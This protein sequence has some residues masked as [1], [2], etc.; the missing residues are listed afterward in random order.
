[1]RPCAG[2]GRST[3]LHLKEF[4]RKPPPAEVRA[5]LR[6]AT[7]ELLAEGAAAH[8]VVNEAVALTRK[9]ERKA[10]GFAGLVNA[11]R[12]QWRRCRRRACR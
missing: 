8:G 5:I 10:E 4:V 2:S 6:L 12:G 1:M 11:V 3:P 7:Y 9:A